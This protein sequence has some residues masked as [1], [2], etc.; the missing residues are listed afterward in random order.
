MKIFSELGKTVED[1]WVDKNYDEELFPEIAAKALKE[2]NL[3]EKV[4][5][6]EVLEWT[7]GQTHLPDQKDLPGRFGDPPITL[8]NSPRFH[9]DTY[10]WLEGTT[11]IH[12]HAF[13]GAFQ[14]LHGSSIHSWYEFDPKVRV[15]T[16]AQVG[17]INLKQCEI[18]SVGDVQEIWA[19]KDYIH[20][21]FHLDQPS[22][23]IV[24][25]THKSPLYLPQFD[26]RKPF[27]ALDPFFE[28]S[29]TTKKLQCITALI[30]SKHPDVD[31]HITGML[32]KADFQS[33]FSI[34]T[35][36][37]GYLS[38]NHIDQMFNLAAPKDRFEGFLDVVRK[39]HGELSDVFPKVFAHQD[40]LNE[41]INRRHYITDPEQRFFLALLLNVEGKDN[42]F[43]LISE[44]YPDASP[45][46]KTLDWVFDL[47]QTRVLGSNIPNALGIEDFDDFDLFVLENLL[48]K[49]SADEI[50]IALKTDYPVD[51]SDAL[52]KEL[53]A[54]M[55]KLQ[56]SALL[57]PLLV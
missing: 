7:L 57:K 24:V 56:N 33:T 28:E 27:L 9:I 3:P 4:N 6:W 34:L 45:L 26:Y 55:E 54:R 43:S 8:Y 47:S 22:V 20:S 5:A 14:V 48:E 49:R 36:V 13:C 32:E 39:R 2:A 23:T 11:S 50:G 15:N 44:K 40:K 51:N 12:Q 30:R 1:L 18:L 37:R 41:I 25:R 42:I 52:K 29:N 21:L 53:P 38:Q 10:F 31:K 35:T 46:D 16:F 19:G 17:D